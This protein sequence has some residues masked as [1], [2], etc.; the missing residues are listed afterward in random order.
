VSWLGIREQ[1]LSRREIFQSKPTVDNAIQ[2]LILKVKLEKLYQ[3]TTDFTGYCCVTQLPFLVE[4][5]STTDSYFFYYA[6]NK[7]VITDKDNE[8]VF[9]MNNLT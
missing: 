9:M 1:V 7:Q 3:K 2:N 5:R 4:W 6:T 8:L